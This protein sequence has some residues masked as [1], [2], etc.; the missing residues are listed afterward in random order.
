MSVDEHQVP[1]VTRAGDVMTEGIELI[2]GDLRMAQQMFD[3]LQMAAAVDG[4][5]HVTITYRAQGG[6]TI[7]VGYGEQ[8][9]PAIVRIEPVHE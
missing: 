5:E 4:V 7:T 1:A 3:V 2:A 6:D 8:A 9:E